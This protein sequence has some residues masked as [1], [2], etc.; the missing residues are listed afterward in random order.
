M[1]VLFILEV[2]CLLSNFTVRTLLHTSEHCVQ[3]SVHRT[4]GLWQFEEN[5]IETIQLIL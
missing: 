2:A 5:R 1:E 4:A 3:C